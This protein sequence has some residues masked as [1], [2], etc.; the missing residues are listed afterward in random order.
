MIKNTPLKKNTPLNNSL[1]N[2]LK[3]LESYSAG[4]K[5]WGIREWA[6]ELDMDP[7]SVSRLAL[8]LRACGYLEKD[9]S[10]KRYILGPKVLR[11]AELYR[12]FNPLTSIA[13]KIFESYLDRFEYNFCFAA[14]EEFTYE[15]IYLTVLDGRGE[16]KVLSLPGEIVPLHA[17][18]LGKAVLAYQPSAYVDSFFKNNSPLKE[19]TKNTITDEILLRGELEKIKSN[20]YARN[21]GEI[22]ESIG[23]IGMPI[24]NPKGEARYAVCLSYPIIYVKEERVLEIINLVKE[25]ALEMKTRFAF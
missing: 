10:T 19:Y 22:Y 4:R 9:P 24:F 20:K 18:A 23:A 21:Y 3:L 12:D 25:I 14:L 1:M 16:V 15:M 2:G 7:S 6:R 17:S 5:S 13:R 11:I 8:T